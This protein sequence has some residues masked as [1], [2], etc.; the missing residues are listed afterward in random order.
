MESWGSIDLLKRSFD[1]L[2]GNFCL[3]LEIHQPDILVQIGRNQA[4]TLQFFKQM[5]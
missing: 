3:V 4:G 1:L 2:Q 5:S